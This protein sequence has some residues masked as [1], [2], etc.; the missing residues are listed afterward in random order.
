MNV[1]DTGQQRIYLC[2]ALGI[3]YSVLLYILAGALHKVPSGHEDKD[4]KNYK[5]VHAAHYKTKRKNWKEENRELSVSWRK[6][7]I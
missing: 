2:P 7:V 6:Y 4:Y 1:R 3:L 5:D